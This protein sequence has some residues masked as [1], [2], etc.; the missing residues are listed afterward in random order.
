MQF[1]A[2]RMFPSPFFPRTTRGTNLLLRSHIS[3]ER[4]CAALIAHTVSYFVQLSRVISFMLPVNQKLSIIRCQK[5]KQLWNLNF[6]KLLKNESFTNMFIENVSKTFESCQHH[7]VMHFTYHRLPISKTWQ[8]TPIQN[9]SH[10]Q[11]KG[12]RM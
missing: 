8:N 6:M 1:C 3:I 2:A 11:R 4:T 12:Q 9:L 7:T 5:I 10:L